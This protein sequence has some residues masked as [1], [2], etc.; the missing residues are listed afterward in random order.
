MNTLNGSYNDLSK[1]QAEYLSMETSDEKCGSQLA[2]YKC[3]LFTFSILHQNIPKM[4]QE[5][6]S[7]E[8]GRDDPV[9]PLHQG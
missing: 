4:C 2:K 1:K 6:G 3:N 5:L 8:E 7:E 9:C